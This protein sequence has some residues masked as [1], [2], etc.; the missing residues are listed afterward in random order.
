MLNIMNQPPYVKYPENPNGDYI[1]L[2][3]LMMDTKEWDEF[4][5][6]Q[7]KLLT[8]LVFEALKNVLSSNPRLEAGQL[9]EKERRKLTPPRRYGILKRD[10]F[11]CV[12]C[13]ATADNRAL[14]V[15]HIVPIALGGKTE[16]ANL[17]TLCWTCN[18]G[19]GA[20]REE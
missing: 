6:C 11:R 14:V 20:K 8:W 2:S 4:P 7:W 19:K 12:L 18:A 5:Y 9:D 16:L 10:D 13:G 15:D 1:L 3:P 17:R